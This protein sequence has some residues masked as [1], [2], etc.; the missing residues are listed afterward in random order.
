MTEQ[1]DHIVVGGG[2]A[3][4]VAAW[5]LVGAGHRVLLLE[6]GPWHRHPLLDMPPGVFKLLKN[7]SKFIKVHASVPQEHL[8]GRIAEVPQGNVLGGGSSV[9]GQVYI[10]GRP[11]DYDR[12]DEILRGNNDAVR[13]SWQDV[14]PH[15][16]RLEGNQRFNNEY[17]GC[18]GPLTVSEPGQV[19]EM[20]HWFVQSLQAQGEPFNPDFNGPTQRGAGYFQFTYR[21]GQRVS[22]AHAFIEPIKDDPNLVLKLEASVHRI[23]VEN[24]RAVG[25]VYRDRTGLHEARADGEIV[26]A[27]G[28]YVTPKLLML[29]GLGPADHLRTH[30]LPV[31]EDLP[32]VGQNL[33]DHP[34]VSI[35][36][37]ANGRYGYFGQDR[38]WA[39]I[40]NG[41]QFKLFGTGPITTTGLEAACFVNPTDPDAPP[42][43]E[44][45]CI[46]ILYLPPEMLEPEGDG[47]GTSIQIVLLKP[48][49]RGEVRLTSAD[50]HAMPA[51]SP[52][53][54][55][56]KRDLDAMIAGLRYFRRTLETRPMADRIDRIVAPAAGRFLGRGAGRPLPQDGEDEFPSR[57]NRQHG[58]RRRPH[59][60][61]R[62]PHAR[63]RRREPARLRHVG[64]AGDF[65]PATPMRRR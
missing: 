2:S 13:W 61:A 64:G 20:A 49:S 23:V 57:R 3:G 40:R 35:V 32:G 26:L 17:H 25:V 62:R 27:A 59:G 6:A 7:G 45:Y 58:G 12:W 19:N 14:L 53:F 56:D 50:P 16:R 43:H 31:V 5:R 10:R 55:R 4:C 52:N 34:D 22:A 30:G 41:L 8:G 15:F 36:A 47:Y 37:R 9:N 1:Y 29:S 63:P 21:R 65:R 28:A 24:G 38:G 18:D 46:P 11:G 54:L 44:A 48:H 39:M 51:I 33:S 60:G 42:T